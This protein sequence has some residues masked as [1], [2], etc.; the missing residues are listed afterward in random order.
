MTSEKATPCEVCGGDGDT[1]QPDHP[2][3]PDGGLVQ[4]S[5]IQ[6][7]PRPWKLAGSN[8]I[9]TADGNGCVGTYQCPGS[10]QHGER[11]W[12]DIYAEA[13]ANG[14]LIVEAVNAHDR[15]ARM[16][17]AGQ[18]LVDAFYPCM[19]KW[20]SENL[21]RWQAAADAFEQASRET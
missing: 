9:Y 21:G 1:C 14:A 5:H 10:R 17:E 6:A 16:A 15:L 3:L 8:G 4:E 19:D 11:S 12:D 2:Y 7:T 18:E 20:S 13:D